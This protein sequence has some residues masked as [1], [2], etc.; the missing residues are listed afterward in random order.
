MLAKP[1]AGHGAR[2]VQGQGA[3]GNAFPLRNALPLQVLTTGGD[4]SLD[5]K[6]DLCQSA[7]VRIHCSV[8]L[9]G[10]G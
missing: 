1:A 2:A 8:R 6:S 5:M 9:P 4:F 3:G 10:A 7:E